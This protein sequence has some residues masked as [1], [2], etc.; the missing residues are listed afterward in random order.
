MSLAPII[1]AAVA[2]SSAFALRCRI[3][4]MVSLDACC[5]GGSDAAASTPDASQGAAPQSTIS[6]AGCCDRLVLTSAKPPADM[7]DRTTVI[8]PATT[9]VAVIAVAFVPPA[10]SVAS[11]VV[12]T[13]GPPGTAPPLYVAKHAFLI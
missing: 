8:A 2:S 9:V 7:A 11:R 5:P 3:T 13:A 1:V 12:G 4:G 6:D 10:S